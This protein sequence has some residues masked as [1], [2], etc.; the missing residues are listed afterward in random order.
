M[1]VGW[2]ALPTPTFDPSVSE[3]NR[4][5]VSGDINDVPAGLKR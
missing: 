3:Y 4:W 2:G 1:Q 5:I